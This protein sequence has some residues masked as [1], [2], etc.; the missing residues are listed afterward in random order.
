MYT[1]NGFVRSEA[2]CAIFLQRARD[3]KRVYATVLNSKTNS[4][5]YKEDSLMHPSGNAHKLLLDECYQECGA[6]KNLLE[7][8]EAHGT[9]TKVSS[10]QGQTKASFSLAIH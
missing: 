3:A 1:A 4:D 7:Y 8:F 5:G 9:G 2:I 6:D 10:L